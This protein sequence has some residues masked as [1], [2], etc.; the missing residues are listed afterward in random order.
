MIFI[1]LLYLTGNEAN[2]VALPVVGCFSTLP[3]SGLNSAPW[4]AQY[5]FEYSVSGGCTEQP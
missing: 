5:I 1:T 4:H 2:D 3:D